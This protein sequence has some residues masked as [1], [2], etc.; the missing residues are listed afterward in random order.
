MLFSRRENNG[1]QN[2]EENKKNRIV[3][4]LKVRYRAT[5]LVKNKNAWQ[6]SKHS[7]SGEI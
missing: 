1:G 6:W 5:I 7:G 4:I 3:S 2:R